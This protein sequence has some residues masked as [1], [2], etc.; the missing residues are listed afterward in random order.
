M[1]KKSKANVKAR[2]GR[3]NSLKPMAPKAGV[4]THK[5]RYGGGGKLK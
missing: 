1:A 5:S 4:T 2:G 3:T